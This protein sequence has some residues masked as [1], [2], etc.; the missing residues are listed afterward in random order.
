MSSSEEIK[1]LTD[2]TYWSRPA[3]GRTRQRQ[4]K[5]KSLSPAT[6]ASMPENLKFSS[7]PKAKRR[8]KTTPRK[9]SSRDIPRKQ[10]P[11]PNSDLKFYGNEPPSPPLIKLSALT[12]KKQEEDDEKDEKAIVKL[13]KS[14]LPKFS[15]KLIGKWQCSN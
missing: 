13:M 12:L 7:Q 10:L 15:T 2:N 11:P 5:S 4:S 8:S 1:D 6:M 14:T 9:T 3:R